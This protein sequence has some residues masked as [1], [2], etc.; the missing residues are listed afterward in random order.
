MDLK[1]G[2]LAGQIPYLM[3]INFIVRHKSKICSNYYISLLRPLRL[4]HGST[5]S[6]VEQHCLLSPPLRLRFVFFA[7]LKKLCWLAISLFIAYYN[8]QH[9]YTS[10]NW[11]FFIPSNSC[12]W[13]SAAMSSASQSNP[14]YNY[15][16]Y[17][18]SRIIQIFVIKQ[19][20]Y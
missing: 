12:C 18:V 2:N 16:P 10:F 11:L 5:D 13:L 17:P 8:W 6:I 15:Q 20:L 3:S 14:N 4:L 9:P 7:S 1:P 19:H